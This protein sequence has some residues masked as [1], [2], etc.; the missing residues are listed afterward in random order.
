MHRGAAR[1]SG[2]TKGG[3]I[4][5]FGRSLWAEPELWSAWVTCRS[6]PLYR[7]NCEENPWGWGHGNSYRRKRYFLGNQDSPSL[8]L[9]L[10]AV[11]LW[12]TSVSCAAFRPPHSLSSFLSPIGQVV[13]STGLVML[14]RYHPQHPTP[15]PQPSSQS[16]CPHLRDY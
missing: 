4:R 10:P 16:V 5:C 7:W 13:C 11:P 12:G 3:P 14:P 15:L 1:D 2:A 9:V 6:Q 8:S